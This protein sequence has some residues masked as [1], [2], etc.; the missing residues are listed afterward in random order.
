MT[1]STDPRDGGPG[2]S[3]VAIDKNGNFDNNLA[4][5]F[6]DHKKVF[7]DITHGRAT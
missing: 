3:K 2:V 7:N 1:F 5:Y 6:A 4:S